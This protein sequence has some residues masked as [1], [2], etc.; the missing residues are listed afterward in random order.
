[1]CLGR[2]VQ[3]ALIAWA[4]TGVSLGVASRS[5]A[6]ETS[7]FPALGQVIPVG[8][9]S[10]HQSV[11]GQALELRVFD[12]IPSLRC[13]RSFVRFEGTDR[14]G[15]AQS[16][17]TPDGKVHIPPTAFVGSVCSAVAPVGNPWVTRAAPLSRVQLARSPP[18]ALSREGA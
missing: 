9:S 7:G 10:N 2:D 5:W 3:H 18:S 6:R 13:C 1:M 4:C 17:D 12:R 14:R 11:G 15:T 16:A 8:C